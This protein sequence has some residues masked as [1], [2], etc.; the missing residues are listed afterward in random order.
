MYFP[1]NRE[2][3]II[4]YLLFCTFLILKMFP[5]FCIIRVC[6]LT[7]YFNKNTYILIFT[8]KISDQLLGPYGQLVVQSTFT[9][10][11]VNNLNCEN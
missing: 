10:Y 4:Q 11:I 7:V 5:D 2:I 1:L 8:P 9:T 6:L 3:F